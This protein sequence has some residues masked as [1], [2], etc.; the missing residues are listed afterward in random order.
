[1]DKLYTVIIMPLIDMA[2][3]VKDVFLTLL[4][5]FAVLIVGIVLA[6]VLHEVIHRVFKEL[7]LDKAAD[8][9]GLSGLLHTGGVKYSLSH[10]LGMIVYLTVIVTYVLSALEVLGITMISSFVGVIMGYVP[11]VITSVV[12]LVF[13]T[14]MAKIIGKIVYMVVSNLHFPNPKLHERITRWA[15]IL[16]VAKMV[17]VELGYEWLFVGTVFHL[18]VGGVVLALALAFGLGGRDMAAGYLARKKGK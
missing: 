14:I 9:V 1:M 7:H 15:V 8:K 6:K 2:M 4:S 12:V 11:H 13:G 18:I 10:L 3:K 5:V 16:F 17:L